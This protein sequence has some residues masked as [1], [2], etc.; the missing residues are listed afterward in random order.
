M[1]LHDRL[2]HCPVD[3]LGITN[4]ILTNKRT[5]GRKDEQTSQPIFNVPERLMKSFHG[6][7]LVLTNLLG[8]ILT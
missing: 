1:I 2:G 6:G 3:P 5:V 8:T 4:A 7:F